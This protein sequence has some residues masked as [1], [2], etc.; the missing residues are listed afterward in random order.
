MKTLASGRG[1]MAGPWVWAR[2]YREPAAGAKRKAAT[3]GRHRRQP[4]AAL[5]VARSAYR[6]RTYFKAATQGRQI[7]HRPVGAI[8]A[9][10][11]TDLGGFVARLGRA[12]G[13]K[14]GRTVLQSQVLVK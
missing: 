7:R 4:L 11:K 2:F 3:Q 6:S 10:A 8:H 12:V 13:R 14:S 9:W 5:N 1:G